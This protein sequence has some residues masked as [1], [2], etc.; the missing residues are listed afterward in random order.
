MRWLLISELV[1]VGVLFGGFALRRWLD[2]RKRKRAALEGV[3][4]TPIRDLADGTVARIAG[5]VAP[6]HALQPSPVD[7]RPC[8]G[9]RLVVGTAIRGDPSNGF[10][11]VLTRE[12]CQTFAI[13]D[14]TGTAIVEGPFMIDLDVDDSSWTDLPAALFRLLE[15][16]GVPPSTRDLRFSEAFLLPGD[17]VTVMGA[18]SVELHPA[19][20]PRLR[21]PPMRRRIFGTDRTPVI[22]RDA[23]DESREGPQGPEVRTTS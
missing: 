8:M 16:A 19:G 15:D 17:R 20:E 9:F 11:Q 5:T 3:P 6:L 21:D 18:V 14:E 12:S 7:Q 10:S 13:S 22:L 4:E 2:P 23:V 1:G